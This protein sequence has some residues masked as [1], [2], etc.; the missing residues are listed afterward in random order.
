LTEFSSKINYYVFVQCKYICHG[1]VQKA[2]EGSYELAD[3]LIGLKSVTYALVIVEFILI[4][5]VDK[6]VLRLAMLRDGNP[7]TGAITLS[8]SLDQTETTP[9]LTADHPHAQVLSISYNTI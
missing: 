1:A 4:C 6:T 2:V 8:A 7:D 5:L 3:S 9:L